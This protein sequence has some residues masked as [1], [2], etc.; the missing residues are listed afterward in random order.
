[1]TPTATRAP[2]TDP[3]AR[4]RRALAALA[5]RRGLPSGQP[6]RRAAM[7]VGLPS[8]AARPARRTEL[9][10]LTPV[11]PSPLFRTARLGLGTAGG[12]GGGPGRG[13]D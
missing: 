7:R 9:P 12:G 3:A 13:V 6:L 1:M 4:L 5:R 2:A 10:V 11:L 8:R